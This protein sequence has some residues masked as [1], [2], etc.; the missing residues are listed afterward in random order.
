MT[1]EEAAFA[2]F[3]TPTGK[4]ALSLGFIKVTK[5]KGCIEEGWNS[6][7]NRYEKIIRIEVQFTKQ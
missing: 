4:M 3:A 2:A 7:T 5:G 1:F 6:K